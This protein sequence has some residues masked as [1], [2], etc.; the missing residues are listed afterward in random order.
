VGR[1]P[2][3]SELSYSPAYSMLSVTKIKINAPQLDQQKL[4]SADVLRP[5]IKSAD[6]KYNFNIELETISKIHEEKKSEAELREL[7]AWKAL[8]DKRNRKPLSTS[9]NHVPTQD[10]LVDLNFGI[11][12]TTRTTVDPAPKPTIPKVVPSPVDNSVISQP[13]KPKPITVNNTTNNFTRA[14][15]DKMGLPP[16]TEQMFLHLVEMGID[17]EII[18]IGLEVVGTESEFKLIN[19]LTEFQKLAERPEK[20][21]RSLIKQALIMYDTDY[22]KSLNFL[23]E[24]HK[25]SQ[26]KVQTEQ[27]LEA[28]SMF[29]NDIMQASPFLLGYQT[30]KELEFPDIKIREA[31]VMCNNDSDKAIQYLLENA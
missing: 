2:A 14:S 21:P 9:N 27:I 17:P 6:F 15:I 5:T 19:F 16:Q 30:L 31:L 3:R 10:T 11:E 1:I 23:N 4:L 28:L 7:E 25:L 8:E 20:F 26:K 22:T 13:P 24:C 29:N 18:P 12:S